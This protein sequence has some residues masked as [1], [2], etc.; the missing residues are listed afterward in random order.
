MI[1]LTVHTSN[2]IRSKN[3]YK[4]KCC[5]GKCFKYFCYIF[6]KYS[7]RNVYPLQVGKSDIYIYLCLFVFTMFFFRLHLPV[8]YH[9]RS[10]SIVVSGTPVRRPCGQSRTDDSKIQYFVCYW[11]YKFKCVS[12]CYVVLFHI[13]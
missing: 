10:S 6:Y 1:A 8:G 12:M 5:V 2:H 13:W 3:T 4:N 11:W 7:S 9:G